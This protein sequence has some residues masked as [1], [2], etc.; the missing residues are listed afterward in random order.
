MSGQSAAPPVSTAE[1]P[2]VFAYLR[3]VYGVCAAEVQKLR[4]DPF[5]LF[6]RAIQPVLWLVLFGEVMAQVHG[7]SSEGMRYIDF[8]SA[9]ILT[10]SVLFVAI[11]YGIAAI[12]E[13]DLGILHR[14]LVSPAPRSALVLG[15]ALSAGVRG[16][17][18]AFVV[19]AL[20]SLLHVAISLAPLRLLSRL[21]EVLRH[22]RAEPMVSGWTHPDRAIRRSVGR[23]VDACCERL[24]KHTTPGFIGAF[25]QLPRLQ[26]VSQL[27]SLPS[28]RVWN[29]ARS[30]A[31]L[32]AILPKERHL[33]WLMANDPV[34]RARRLP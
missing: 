6:T 33:H 9:G 14:Y 3:Q 15:K 20:A 28:M 13:R 19:Y 27:P 22:A 8:L 31:G 23:S 18:Q 16:L 4:H 1:P 11:F 2:A 25:G 29:A 26:K 32:S 10:Q 30:I 17:T 24:S 34:V 21:P 5:E 7:L 12:W